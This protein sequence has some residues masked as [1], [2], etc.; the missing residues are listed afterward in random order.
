M[1]SLVFATAS[2][3]GLLGFGWITVHR[4]KKSAAAHLEEADRCIAD[5]ERIAGRRHSRRQGGNHRQAAAQPAA[6]HLVGPD[7]K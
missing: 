7:P 6:L 3:L 4:S 1:L 2:I 5:V